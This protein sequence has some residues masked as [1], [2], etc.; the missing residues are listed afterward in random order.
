[1][2]EVHEVRKKNV[3]LARR[4][5]T[6]FEVIEPYLYLFPA[7][8]LLILLIYYPF[9]TTIGKSF[10]LTNYLGEIRRFVGFE[11]YQ[12][13][14][15]DAVFLKAIKNTMVFTII[16]VPLSVGISFI[17]A[18]LCNK[19]RTLSPVYETFFSLPMAMSSS[20]ACMIFEVMFNP[21][22]GIINRMLNSNMN[23]LSNKETAMWVLIIIRVWMNIGYNFLFLLSAIRALPQEVIESAE[24]EGANSIQRAVKIVLPLISPTVFFLACNS[25]AKTM[26]MSG[27]TLILTPEGG[28]GRSTET[29]ISFMYKA[30]AESQNY[31]VGYPAAFFA[32]CVTL[33]AV[34]LTFV[35]EKKGVHYD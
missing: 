11:N 16:V 31:N 35:F 6:A 7:F 1:M 19:K 29:M 18:V 17:L 20:V 27:L 9:A 25:L 2:C 33:L 21:S 26:T 14:L 12:Y 4:K 10:F 13:L 30:V 15:K 24:L 8:A 28:P 32:F 5:K 23:W 3:R 34:V 22:L